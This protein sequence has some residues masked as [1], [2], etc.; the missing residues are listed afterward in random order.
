[1]K[2]Q[3]ALL[4]LLLITSIGSSIFGQT[5]K[6]V[7]GFTQFY[8]DKSGYRSWTSEHWN[9]GIARTFQYNSDPYDPTD[10]TEDHSASGPAYAVNGS[11]V[12][13]MSGS[14][15]FHI[16]PLRNSKVTAQVFTNIEFTAYYRKTGANG[17][18]YG[19]MIVGMRGSSLGHGSS[20]GNVCD[21]QS[22]QARF[23][24]DGKWDF[25]KELKHP[26]S[27]YYSGSGY[28]TQDPLWKGKKLPE[29]KW[30]GMKYI[31]YNNAANTQ[32]T[33][34]VYV[35]STSN[36]EPTNGGNWQLVGKVTD[37]GSNWPGGDISGC[38]YTDKYMPI[39]NGGNVYWR[40]DGDQAEYKYVTI[41]EIEINTL[42]SIADANTPF[43]F[44]IGNVVT[45]SLK[46][47]DEVGYKNATVNIY[48][49]EGRLMHSTAYSTSIDVSVLVLGIYVVEVVKG[50]LV[51]RE[52]FVKK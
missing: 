6:N 31:L 29:N 37:T 1:M 4:A 46:L 52:R 27:T 10:W 42:T 49:P 13:T 35:D 33:L 30:I 11:G 22:Y 15:R 40:T 51:L 16:N 50:R 25:E 47:A 20:G 18:N 32:V 7:F 2:T 9:N 34:E 8:P 41:R 24:N 39:L 43:V 26:A 12:M 5:S 48:S 19:G 17:Q 23:R 28:N 21:A 3:I 38:S 44:L 45:D 14:P 36:A